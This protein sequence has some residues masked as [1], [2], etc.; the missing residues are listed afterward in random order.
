MKKAV[1]TRVDEKDKEK[2]KALAK[3]Y[4]MSESVLLRLLINAVNVEGEK[5]MPLVF[6]AVKQKEKFKGDKLT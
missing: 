2:F 1:A 6:E 5:I 3:R 4:Q